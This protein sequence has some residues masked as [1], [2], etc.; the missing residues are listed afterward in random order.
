MIEYKLG[1]CRIVTEE[2]IEEFGF[3]LSGEINFRGSQSL[4][5]LAEKAANHYHSSRSNS[6]IEGMVVSK[7][8]G[9][10]VLYSSWFVE[11]TEVSDDECA[12]FLQHFLR[13]YNELKLMQSAETRVIE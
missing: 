12:K 13:K 1:K 9:H 7:L 2:C 4:Q 6:G 3:Y 10:A 11:H 5:S 8:Q